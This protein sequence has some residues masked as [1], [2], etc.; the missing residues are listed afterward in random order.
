M[1]KDDALENGFYRGRESK[2]MEG[3]IKFKKETFHRCLGK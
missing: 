3:T 2:N 1:K